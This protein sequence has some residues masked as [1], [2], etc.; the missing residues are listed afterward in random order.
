MKIAFTG[1]LIA[2]FLFEAMAAATMISG[3]GAMFGPEQPDAVMWGRTYGFAALAVASLIFWTW[4]H[5]TSLA[6]TGAI[7]GFLSTF[8]VGITTALII[9]SY[10]TGPIVLHAILAVASI[11]MFTQ[12]S[13]WCD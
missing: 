12:R 10:M 1:L 5:R 13:K 7:L 2:N 6:A 8:H 4:P 9:G 11:F 3:A